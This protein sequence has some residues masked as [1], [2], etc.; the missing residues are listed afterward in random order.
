MP[1]GRGVSLDE[2]GSSLTR[3][4]RPM[5][6]ALV[7]A[8]VL[9]FAGTTSAQ[10][11]RAHAAG[12]CGIG[13]SRHYGYSYL[14]WLWAYKVS[15]GTARSVA[16]SHGK[17]W[18]CHKRILDKVTHPVRREGVVLGVAQ[19]PGPVDLHPEHLIL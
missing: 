15:C 6:L 18:R 7:A 12:T 17:G 9:A 14:T 19:A 10:S 16:R 11:P 13:N 3:L 4:F 1:L 8:T 5:L 2:E